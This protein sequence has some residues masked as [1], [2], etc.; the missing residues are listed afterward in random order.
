MRGA[1]LLLVGVL[2]AACGGGQDRSEVTVLAAASLTEAFDELADRYEAE[3]PGV[4]VALNLAGSQQLAGLVLAGAPADVLATAD[5]TQM[6]R[7]EQAGLLEG[8]PRVF[9]TNQL[10]VVVERGNP[11]SVTAL[12]DLARDDLVLVLPDEAVPAGRYAAALLDRAGVAVQ[13]ASREV[14]VR[15]A[16]GKVRL[17][18]AD[19]AIGYRTDA[20]ALADVDAVEIGDT[21]GVRYAIAALDDAPH[22]DHARAFVELVRSPTGQGILSAHGFGAP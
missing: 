8:E 3:H 20:L 12:R 5:Q 14:D 15:A 9:A 6:A 1:V 11:L 2:L 16:V 22:P 19:V 21:P 17:G 10:V 7:V 13:P 4:T 18:E